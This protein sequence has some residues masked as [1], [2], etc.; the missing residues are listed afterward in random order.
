MPRLARTAEICRQQSPRQGTRFESV[1]Q[2]ASFKYQGFWGLIFL[3]NPPKL[4]KGWL[5]KWGKSFRRVSPNLLSCGQILMYSKH[6]WLSR[7]L[8]GNLTASEFVFSKCHLKGYVL[9]IINFKGCSWNSLFSLG[10]WCPGLGQ[11]PHSR[12]F[13]FYGYSPVSRS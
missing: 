4:P 3:Q 2:E 8:Q 5:A 12:P 10:N 11:R 9:T 6:F 7:D 1:S 13:P